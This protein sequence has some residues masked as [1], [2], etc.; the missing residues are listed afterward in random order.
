MVTPLCHTL[1]SIDDDDNHAKANEVR[2]TR[3]MFQAY[4]EGQQRRE[5]VKGSLRLPPI[6]HGSIRVVQATSANR[7]S[8]VTSHRH[9]LA[10]PPTSPPGFR[11]KERTHQ[12][13]LTKMRRETPTTY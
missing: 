7:F 5:I 13:L 1:V 11:M 4:D 2:G 8:P 9:S 6:S 3:Q 12:F 10:R